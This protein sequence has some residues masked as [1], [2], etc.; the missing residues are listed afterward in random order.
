[1]EWAWLWSEVN[2]SKCAATRERV[3]E[4]RVAL[5]MISIRSINSQSGAY[6]LIFGMETAQVLKTRES[7][8]YSIHVFSSSKSQ[9]T[10]FSCDQV[11]WT[12]SLFCGIFSYCSMP[13]GSHYSSSDEGTLVQSF[14]RCN[15]RASS[16]L[17]R[18]LNSVQKTNT[19]FKNAEPL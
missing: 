2:P 17:T 13:S 4:I 12:H 5:K 1:M 14:F 16:K 9:Q 8:S 15:R 7:Y 11:F 10:T 3:H 18:V 19:F 6:L